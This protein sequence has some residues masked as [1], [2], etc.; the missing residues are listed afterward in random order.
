VRDLRLYIEAKG[1][2][3]AF[4]GTI[5]A[6]GADV[7]Q[8]AIHFWPASGGTRHYCEVYGT[9]AQADFKIRRD[10]TNMNLDAVSL[11]AFPTGPFRLM[12]RA[13]GTSVSCELRHGGQS[14]FI[15]APAP[16]LDET[17]LVYLNV[18]DSRVDVDMFTLL[19]T[20]P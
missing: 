17:E 1:H 10:G 12:F 20:A 15:S 4:T 13:D 2:S 6:L 18:V 9:T 19:E 11:G 16:P 7:H 3:F 8:V 14:R 5:E